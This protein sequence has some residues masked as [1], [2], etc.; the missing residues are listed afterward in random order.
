MSYLVIG[1]LAFVGAH[2]VPAV[3]SLRGAVEAR[4]GAGGRRIL[5]SVLSAIGLALMIYGYG[6]ARA[7]GALVLWDPPRWT[8]H[9][10]ATLLIPVFPLLIATY[11]PGRI[12]A[13]VKHPMLTAVKL[14]ALAHLVAN[15]TLPDVLLFGGLL[16]W[17]VFDR[18]SVKRRG[19]PNPPASPWTS[20][21]TVAVVAGLALYGLTVWRLHLWLIGV[22]PV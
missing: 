16:A 8:R 4:G 13:A 10:A 21:D 17:A 7:E 6:A 3:P 2:L 12:K 15:G 20:G 22:S 11:V 1:L 19:L 9:L 14:W 18:I 5:V